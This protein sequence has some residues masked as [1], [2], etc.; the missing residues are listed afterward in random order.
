MLYLYYNNIVSFFLFYFNLVHSIIL[1][2]FYVMENLEN[3][4]IKKKMLFPIVEHS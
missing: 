4:R 1:L 3:L 2:D